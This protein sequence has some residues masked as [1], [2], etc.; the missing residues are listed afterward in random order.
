MHV[1]EVLCVPVLRVLEG[2][3]AGGVFVRWDLREIPIRGRA[4]VRV[5]SYE[6]VLQEL[7]WRDS[8][9]RAEEPTSAVLV[10]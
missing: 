3:V 1:L 4:V 8:G 6:F 2:K 9:L 7:G 5:F 10:T